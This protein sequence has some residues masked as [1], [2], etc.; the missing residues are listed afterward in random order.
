M[1]RTAFWGLGMVLV[2]WVACDGDAGERDCQDIEEAFTACGGE[3]TGDWKITRTCAPDYEPTWP[4]QG[5]CPEAETSSTF[6]MDVLAD[7]EGTV[8]EFSQWLLLLD[9][10]VFLPGACVQAR[11]TDCEALEDDEWF[12]FTG[13]IDCTR[14]QGGC[15]CTF[16]SFAKEPAKSNSYRVE[17]ATMIMDGEVAYPLCVQGEGMVWDTRGKIPG[18]DFLMFERRAVYRP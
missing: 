11:R 10:T 6:D 14:D 3:P 4:W 7:I 5:E 15:A 16:S 17:G 12:E 9:G 2:A 1:C 18:V 13:M 8:A